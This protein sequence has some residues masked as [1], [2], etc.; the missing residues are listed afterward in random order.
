MSDLEQTVLFEE[1][2]YLAPKDMNNIVKDPIDKILLKHLRGKI[3]NKCSQ[4]GF[5]VP[6]SL[7][8][9]SRSAGQLENGRFTG[10]IVFHCQLQA[11]VY[12][13]VNGTRIVGTIL[14]R[15]KMGLYVIYKDAIRVLIPRDLHLGNEEFESLQVDETIE[16]EIRKSR[17][18]IQDPFIL[19]VGIYIR[20][21][22][23][24]RTYGTIL[25]E[26]LEED[27]SSNQNKKEGTSV[28]PNR[29][30]EKKPDEE[31]E[32]DEEGKETEEDITLLNELEVE[33]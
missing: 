29:K 18:Q 33:A 13:P 23:A 27:V 3:E 4:H 10:N 14:K 25:E 15:N 21:V 5:V 20:R 7:Q 16:I 19:S 30:Q 12:N 11:R 8:I 28:L 2:A 6:K 9:L 17:F 1:K 31:E 32:G 26:Q 22:A 24:E